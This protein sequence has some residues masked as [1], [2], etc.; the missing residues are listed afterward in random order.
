MENPETLLPMGMKLAFGAP[1]EAKR[2][3]LVD[4]T[5][6]FIALRFNPKS[7]LWPLAEPRYSYEKRGWVFMCVRKVPA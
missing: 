2:E 5:R 7:D 1:V 3:Q 6:L 4:A